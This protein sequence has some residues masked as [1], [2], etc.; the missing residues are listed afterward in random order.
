MRVPLQI[1][2]TKKNDGLKVSHVKVKMK[3]I[4]AIIA[5]LALLATANAYGE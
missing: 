2:V 5:A 1:L 4:G 3:G